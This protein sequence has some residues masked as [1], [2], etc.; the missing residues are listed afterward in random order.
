MLWVGIQLD[1]TWL[2]VIRATSRA[3]GSLDLD[4]SQHGARVQ[5]VLREVDVSVAHEPHGLGKA[6][7]TRL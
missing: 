6:T 3:N 4:L 7:P 2:V 1:A 5:H